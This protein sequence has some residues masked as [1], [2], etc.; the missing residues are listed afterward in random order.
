MMKALSWRKTTM[1]DRIDTP[2]DDRKGCSCIGPDGRP[3]VAAVVGPEATP[4]AR[5]DTLVRLL[6]NDELSEKVRA[7]C[8]A[9]VLSWGCNAVG[10]RTVEFL[11]LTAADYPPKG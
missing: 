10:I 8:R 2:D 9:V 11:R 7:G 6:G 3:V 4:A 5:L 1:T